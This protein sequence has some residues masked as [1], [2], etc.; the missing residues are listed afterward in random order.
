MK[1]RPP[2]SRLPVASGL[3]LL[4]AFGIAQAEQVYLA[5]GN[6]GHRMISPDAKTW[7]H[8]IAWGVPR[9]DTN[10]LTSIAFFKGAAYVGGGYFHPRITAT[11]DG[12]HWK[13]GALAGGGGP[14]MGLEVVDDKLYA[15]T[16]RGQ[17]FAS[18]DGET[19]ES[20]AKAEV[21]E[22]GAVRETVHA[23]GRIVGAG[24]FGL[25]V[26]YVPETGTIT[27]L[28]MAGQEEKNAT[29]RRIAHGKETFVVGGANGLLAWSG[30]G[31][32]WQN[33]EA[34]P[35][36]GDIRDVVW[37]GNQFLALADKKGEPSQ[38]LTSPDGR[39]WTASDIEMPGRSMLP[40][41]DSLYVRSGKTSWKYSK[42]LRTWE[43]LPNPYEASI[44]VIESGELSG[45][46]T[47]P[48][49]PEDPRPPKKGSPE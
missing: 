41:G 33:N 2:R 26:T 34:V 36:R 1:R 17:V 23:N 42:D 10:D 30:D 27:A 43:D 11:R 16:I 7:D 18:E 48:N 44:K 21:D 4:A 49:L 22:P 6:G 19:F 5:A 32:T 45:D 35:E 9:H 24:D 25:V 8:H 14:L 3:A 15:M 46:A 47:P 13:D 39:E 12:I 38:V 31:V 29:F 37:F 40:V 28:R 20:V